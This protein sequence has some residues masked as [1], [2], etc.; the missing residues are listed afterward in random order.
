MLISYP[1]RA[2]KINGKI[3]GRKIKLFIFYLLILLKFLKET[4]HQND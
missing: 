4:K 1:V 3:M 2:K